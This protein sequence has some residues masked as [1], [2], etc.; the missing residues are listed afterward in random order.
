MLRISTLIMKV[1]VI[2]AVL[3]AVATAGILFAVANPNSVADK[4]CEAEGP[5]LIYDEG[6]QETTVIVAASAPACHLGLPAGTEYSVTLERGEAKSDQGPDLKI[7]VNADGSFSHEL[8]VDASELPSPMT[9]IVEAQ[10]QTAE[11]EEANSCAVRQWSVV[12][13]P[14]GR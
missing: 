9:A 6:E 4:Y 1:S 2:S 8:P 13:E 14:R 11:C 10:P 3:I 7:P 5:Q 12:I